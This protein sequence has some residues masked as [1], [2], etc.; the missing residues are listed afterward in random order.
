MKKIY[1]VIAAAITGLLLGLAYHSNAQTVQDTTVH[2]PFIS[3]EFI[4]EIL[5]ITLAYLQNPAGGLFAAISALFLLIVRRFEIKKIKRKAVE[6]VQ[7]ELESK[8]AIIQDIESPQNDALNHYT[9]ET[10]KPNARESR[11]RKWFNR[12]KG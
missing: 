11:R 8:S 12:K 4:T 7:N 1:K 10:K 6:S 9:D 3:I 2:S 5:K